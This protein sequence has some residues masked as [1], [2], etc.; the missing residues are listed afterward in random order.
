MPEAAVPMPLP[1]A[2]NTNPRA[3]AALPEGW[4][5]EKTKNRL[6]IGFKVSDSEDMLGKIMKVLGWSAAVFAVLAL[7][8][9]LVEQ[10]NRSAFVLGLAA[11]ICLALML[12][13]H[14]H[15]RS[16]YLAT[17]RRHLWLDRRLTIKPLVRL[18]IADICQLYV[19]EQVR[20]LD[21]GRLGPYGARTLADYQLCATLKAG[22]GP[23]TLVIA[24]FDSP[25]QALFL[26]QMF[27]EF[28]GIVDRQVP[29]EV[30]APSFAM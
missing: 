14:W 23:R 19:A 12:P 18:P 25:R 13:L 30:E 4:T 27:E 8:H 17:D 29:G 22:L 10:D 20:H 15:R 21:G 9:L 26:E 11:P 7:F 2:V 5:V 16:M 3:V 6:Q 28:L 1:K 24:T